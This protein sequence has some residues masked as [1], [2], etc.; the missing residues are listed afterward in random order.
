[1]HY[2]NI[3]GDKITVAYLVGEGRVCK[4]QSMIRPVQL[5]CP[6]KEKVT[7]SNILTGL[8]LA[9]STALIHRGIIFDKLLQCYSIYFCQ[10]MH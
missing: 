3:S 2:K 1:M 9:L 8:P 6:A 10:E 7:R 5:H 4:Y